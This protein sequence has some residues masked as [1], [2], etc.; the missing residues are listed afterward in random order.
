LTVEQ[1]LRAF[2]TFYR[3]AASLN[4]KLREGADAPRAAASVR[5]LKLP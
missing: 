5:V 1:R 2:D 3:L 4:P